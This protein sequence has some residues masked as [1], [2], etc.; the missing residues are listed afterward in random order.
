MAQPRADAVWCRKLDMLARRFMEKRDG[1]ITMSE[2]S[3]FKFL[4]CFSDVV[5]VSR[6]VQRP[7]AILHALRPFRQNGQVPAFHVDALP[8]IMQHMGATLDADQWQET[9]T[10]LLR[11]FDCPGQHEVVQHGDCAASAVCQARPELQQMSKEDL[12]ALVIT[13][14][15]NTSAV[16]RKLNAAT[17]RASRWQHKCEMLER[18]N[19]ELKQQVLV[20]TSAVF[21]WTVFARVFDSSL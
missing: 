4:L 18:S 16:Q 1:T 13:T 5:D 8:V 9:R 21:G 15:E 7:N 6:T 20:K 19:E 2:A 10:G 11:H 3:L 14:E 17:K 12:V